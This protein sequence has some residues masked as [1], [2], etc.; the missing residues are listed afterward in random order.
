MTKCLTT[1]NGYSESVEEEG[2]TTKWPK[3]LRQMTTNDLQNTTQINTDR[4][5][6]TSSKNRGLT[7]GLCV[8]GL[9]LELYSEGQ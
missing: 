7:R 1:P 6:R 3:E 8:L 2:Q 9:H 5:T 4:V